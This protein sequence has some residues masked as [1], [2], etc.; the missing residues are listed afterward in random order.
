[1]GE[2]VVADSWGTYGHLDRHLSGQRYQGIDPS[3][4]TS[5]SLKEPALANVKDGR[6]L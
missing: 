3:E 5:D 6:V 1:M 4:M 2:A